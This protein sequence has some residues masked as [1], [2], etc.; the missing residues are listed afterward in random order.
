MTYVGHGEV[1][2][3]SYLGPAGQSGQ[4]LLPPAPSDTPD[5]D[6]TAVELRNLTVDRMRQ[7]NAMHGMHA[8]ERRRG[9]DAIG[10]HGLA[11]LYRDTDHTGDQPRPVV[12]AATRL[13]LDGEDVRRIYHLLDEMVGI[14]RDYLTKGPFD[15]RRTMANRQDQMTER[16]EYLGIGISTLDSREGPWAEV[17]RRAGSPLEVPGVSYALLLDGTRLVVDRGGGT[18]H[19]TARVY[20]THSLTDPANPVRVWT[21]LRDPDGEGLGHM[22]RWLGALHHLVLAGARR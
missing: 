20:S 1:P 19:G 13:F 2:R 7:M 18:S 14:A 5:A 17:L 16:A 15:P 8:Y 9:R 22:W 4:Q 12:R 11:F 6:R 3:H 21:W 10:P